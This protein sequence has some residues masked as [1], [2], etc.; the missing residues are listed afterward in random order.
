MLQL[1][2]GGLGSCL[3]HKRQG[4]FLLLA[5]HLIRDCKM[6]PYRARTDVL[7]P[8]PL[9]PSLSLAIASELS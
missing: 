9:C 5:G 8:F 2:T 7:S 1:A 4:A 3:P 6:V